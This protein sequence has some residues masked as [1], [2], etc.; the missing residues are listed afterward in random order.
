M[1]GLQLSAML[2]QM[3]VEAPADGLKTQAT[4]YFN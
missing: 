2:K 4:I 3:G 1:N